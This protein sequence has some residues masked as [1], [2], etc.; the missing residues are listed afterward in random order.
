MESDLMKYS[1]AAIARSKEYTDETADRLVKHFVEAINKMP[2]YD[3]SEVSKGVLTKVLIEV[4][5]MIKS[6]VDENVTKRMGMVDARLGEAHEERIAML[7]AIRS[8]PLPQVH[9]T[10][11]ADAITFK[12]E[13]AQVK[14]N[15]AAPNVRVEAAAAPNVN[16]TVPEKAIK[17]EAPK[18]TMKV[19]KSILYDP[20]SG[21]PAK[22]V[23][24]TTEN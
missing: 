17:I 3:M 24:E 2:I 4:V 11:P 8:I 14:V 15:V 12:Q 21:R 6:L 1:K 19:E 10:V 9:V 13:P 22:I 18:R 5:P 20:Q 23:E 16:F 7:N